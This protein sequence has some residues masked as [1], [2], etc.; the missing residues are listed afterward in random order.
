MSA[1][2][3]RNVSFPIDMNWGDIKRIKS[4]VMFKVQKDG[5]LDEIHV[6][7]TNFSDANESIIEV[8]EMMTNWV[9]ADYPCAAAGTLVRVPV[10]IELR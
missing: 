4:Y 1:F 7:W 3:S 5:S 10:S 9:G 8:F 2:I 6:V